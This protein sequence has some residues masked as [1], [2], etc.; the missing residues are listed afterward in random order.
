M[1]AKKL[2]IVAD[3]LAEAN[4]TLKSQIPDGYWID[5][6]DVI[7]YGQN[8][9]VKKK[10]FTIDGA[11]AQA[12]GE[13]GTQAIVTEE[14]V[15]DSPRQESFLIK[16]FDEQSGASQARSEIQRRFGNTF[17]FTG[18]KLIELGSKG[19]FG[20]GSKPNE[21]E[22]QAYQ[23]AS[24]VI[25][26]H[27]KAEIEASIITT[28]VYIEKLIED[29]GN[30]KFNWGLIPE[31][32]DSYEVEITDEGQSI[33]ENAFRSLISLGAVAVPQLCKALGDPRKPK[34]PIHI[35]YV[36]P[37]SASTFRKNGPETKDGE[38]VGQTV[39]KILVEI[40]E[41]NL[42]KK[43]TEVI[44]GVGRNRALW[45]LSLLGDNDASKI[46]GSS[47]E[48]KS[49]VDLV[50]LDAGVRIIETIKVI[51]NLTNLGLGDAKEL[52]ETRNGVILRNVSKSTAMQ[53]QL[54][55]ESAGAVTKIV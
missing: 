54:L 4:E 48:E 50:I 13:A 36:Y 52:A 21:Y 20:I 23:P 6:V 12:R 24:V 34:I 40:G 18:I 38:E 55:F 30:S 10:D 15:I 33:R 28:E 37:S 31:P 25:V 11:L 27:D 1:E 51:R 5:K 16:A 26:Y 41:R 3:S 22:I 17:S 39:A 43:Q 47:E 9:V 46:E 8:K 44:E 53:A 49:F 32:D 2:N 35:S 19:F 14:H 45:V 42:V 29:L 7:H